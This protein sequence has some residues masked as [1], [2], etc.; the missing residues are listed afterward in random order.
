MTTIVL[1]SNLN[2][3]CDS[4]M[5]ANNH[6]VGDYADKV[7]QI[8]GYTIGVAGRY[9][10]CLAFIDMMEDEIERL[11]VQQTTFLPIPENVVEDMD[12]FSA[13]L[14]SPDGDVFVFE[15]SRFSIPSQTPICIGSG[16]EYA[17]GALAMGAT[18]AEAVEVASKYDLYTGGEIKT[19]DCK[20]AQ[21]DEGEYLKYDELAKLTKKQILS[22]LF[23]E[24]NTEET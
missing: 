10:E 17:Y 14:V 2:M 9:A 18:A 13:I 23:P 6:L 16:S 7:F 20:V 5:A 1:D 4:R 19:F 3:A 8:G 12:N 24:D 21:D 22:K 15:S 11:R